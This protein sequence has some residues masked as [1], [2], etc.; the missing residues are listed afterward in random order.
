MSKFKLLCALSVCRDFFYRS[1]YSNVNYAFIVILLWIYA[2]KVVFII[3]LLL[4][5]EKWVGLMCICVY[6]KGFFTM[7]RNSPDWMH[8]QLYKAQPLLILSQGLCEFFFC[9]IWD[10]WICLFEQQS[11]EDTFFVSISCQK[12]MVKEWYRDT[13]W[14]SLKPACI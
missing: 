8:T 5:S 10:N 4:F 6:Q 2:K 1:I 9:C 13:L 12:V 11:Y 14:G 3:N 7:S